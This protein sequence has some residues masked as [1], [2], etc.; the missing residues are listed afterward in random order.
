M[1]L[2]LQSMGSLT[3]SYPRRNESLF[4]NALYSRNKAQRPPIWL[5]RQAGRSLPPYQKLRSRFSLEELFHIPEYIA[6]ITCQPVDVLKVD[7]AIL[8]ADILHILI[9]LGWKV[10]F[11]Q[12][13]GIAILPKVTTPQAAL[14]LKEISVWESLSFVQQGIFLAKKHLQVPLIGFCGAPFTVAYYLSQKEIKKWIY[15][16][17]KAVHLLLRRI[18]KITKEYLQLQ[19]EGGVDAIQIFDSWLSLLGEEELQIFALPYLNQLITFLKDKGIPSLLFAR[20]SC[21]FAQ[22]L[23][24]LSPTGLSVDWHLSLSSLRKQL[25]PLLALQGNLDPAVLYGSFDLIEKKAVALL[26]SMRDDKGFIFN[27]GHGM[28]PDISSDHIRCLVDTV[29]GFSWKRSKDSA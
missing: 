19:I 24:S 8:F 22:N 28:L 5:M 9:P 17:P 25:S 21:L 26:E 20:G 10:S 13:G 11:P 29:R 3:E 12:Q 27:L 2:D 15:T 1:N 14:Q 16:D 7:A 18:T 23:A 4:L 6:E